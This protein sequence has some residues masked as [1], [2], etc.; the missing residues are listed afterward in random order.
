MRDTKE[1]DVHAVPRPHFDATVNW[2]H[3][4]IVVTFIITAAGQWYLTDY[5]LRSVEEQVK[6]GLAN[7][8]TLVVTS[9][10][11]DERIS[12]FGRRL[13]RIERRP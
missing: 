9:A 12:E 7:L 2:G 10:R 1:Q 11:Q 6:S 5:R 8:G 3:V 13:D 4:L